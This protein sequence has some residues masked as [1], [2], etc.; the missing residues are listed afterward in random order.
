[1][2]ELG[3]VSRRAIIGALCA[4]ALVSS[5][6]A[7]AQSG[8]VVVASYGGS[9]Q[10]AQA[11]AFFDPFAAA[12][13]LEV[14]GAT[15]SSY[16]KV[17]AMVESGSVTWDVVS[18]ESSAF[19]NE[20]KDGLLMPLDYSVIKADGIPD[21]LRREFGVGYIK[22]GQN[23]AWDTDKFPNGVS[24]ADFFNPEIKGRRA[25]TAEP[26]YTLE[27]AL[28]ADGV[29]PDALYPLDVDRA[30]AVIDRVKDQ[31][32]A[33]K[34]S[35]DIQALI[36][37]GELDMAFIPNGRISDAIE[38]G[39]P[40]AYG[41]DASVSDTEWWVVPK[42][43][44]HPENAM[45][46]IDFAVQGAQQAALANA[47]P[48]GPTNLDAFPLLDPAFAKTLPSYPE[49]ASVGAV[50]DPTWWSENLP[51]VSARWNDYLLQ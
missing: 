37:Q 32:V 25:L 17:K 19:V 48:Y 50:L 46:F 21:S 3:T 13:G 20:A 51:A 42:G 24:P 49:N 43:A 8:Q 4:A 34:G 12:S 29:A 27:F 44:P 47:I 9:F 23:L 40:W 39:A 5:G 31:V 1:M 18:A 45:K 14:V 30:L 33:F 15:G 6:M 38:A 41:W 22:F 35:A 26:S 28:L 7:I 16:N 2:R 10:D 36:Q 11:K